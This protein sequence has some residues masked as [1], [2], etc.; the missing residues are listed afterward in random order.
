MIKTGT[1]LGDR[2][3]ILEKIGTGGMAEVFKGKDHKLN[4]YVAV[5]VLKEEFRDNDGFV[6]K[7]KEEAQAAAGLAH[8]NVVNVYDVGDENGIY[9]IVMEMV[10]GIT[11]KNYIERKGRLTI[12]EATSIQFRYLQDWRLPIIIILYTGISNHRTLL[13]P[14]KE[15]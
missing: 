4:R 15:K 1:I 13:F 11:L 9:Y 7:F 5:K 14:E 10:E 6:K 12:K 2:Y 3:E 8:P